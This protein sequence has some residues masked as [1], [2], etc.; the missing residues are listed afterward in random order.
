MFFRRAG[1]FFNPS[2][3]FKNGAKSVNFMGVE[4]TRRHCA[5][6]RSSLVRGFVDPKS[7]LSA[8]ASAGGAVT[9]VSALAS[10]MGVAQRAISLSAIEDL[11]VAL[12][13][14]IVEQNVSTP[15]SLLSFY[16]PSGCSCGTVPMTRLW[17]MMEEF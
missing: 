2:T 15:F 17:T 9:V 8:S 5:S 14:T 13:N 4:M 7:F 6:T 12:L 10:Q 16:V 3:A 1:G 11:D